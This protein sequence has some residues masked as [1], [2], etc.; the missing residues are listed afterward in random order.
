LDRF[1]PSSSSTF[2]R[3]NFWFN[4]FSFETIRQLSFSRIYKCCK[5]PNRVYFSSPPFVVLVDELSG[6]N[7]VLFKTFISDLLH[8]FAIQKMKT[9]LK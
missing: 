6:F 2:S 4:Y 5:D 7:G 1:E 9:K 3:L 8:F